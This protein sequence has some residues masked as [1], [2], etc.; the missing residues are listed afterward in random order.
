MITKQIAVFLENQQGRLKKLLNAIA[1]GNEHIKCLNIADTKEFG[2]V[3]MLVDN[4][5]NT[6]M[7]I[8]NAGFTAIASDVL[9]IELEDKAGSLAN[10]LGKLD[11]NNISVEYIYSYCYKKG[12]ALL[13]LKVDNLQLAQ[14]VLS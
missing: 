4:I 14:E 3:R 10:V 13:I 8:R 2:V 1:D 12:K 7:L 9:A 11:D 6:M 5:D